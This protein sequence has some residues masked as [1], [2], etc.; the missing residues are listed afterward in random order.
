MI[1]LSW[2]VLGWAIDRTLKQLDSFTGAVAASSA[3][4]ADPLP[5]A[6]VPVELVSLVESMN[7]LIARLRAAIEAQRRFVSDAAHELRT[8]LAALQI[9]A[10]N[11]PP[12]DASA[13]ARGAIR[14]GVKRA[15]DLVDRLLRLARLDESGAPRSTPLDLAALA[16]DVLA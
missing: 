16:L 4:A 13:A 2:L 3:A 6:G 11:L 1:P 8:P 5:Q 15:S 7:G 10:G 14:D 12:D 9:Q